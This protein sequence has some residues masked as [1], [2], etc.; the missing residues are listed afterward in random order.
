MIEPPLTISGPTLEALKYTFDTKELREMY[1]ELLSSSMNIDTV[2]K[3]HSSY[4]EIIKNMTPLDA[5]ILKVFSEVDA[6]PSAIITFDIEN[7]GHFLE[8]MPRIFAP[9]LLKNKDIFLIA[10]SIT[11]LC[12]LGLLSYTQELWLR[13]YNYEALKRHPLVLERYNRYKTHKGV[14]IEL[15]K[16]LIERTDFGYNFIKTCIPKT[17]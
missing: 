14:T 16:A 5:I 15:R 13:D 10:A 2:N 6:V 8:G 17:W 9:H 12:R 1:I 11:N 4:V 7:N 3:A